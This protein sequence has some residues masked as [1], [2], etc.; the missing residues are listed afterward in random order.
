MTFATATSS[1]STSTVCESCWAGTLLSPG[2]GRGTS[3]AR[4]ES[5]SLAYRLHALLMLGLLVAYGLFVA[6]AWFSARYVVV[7]SLETRL[8]HDRDTLL[9]ALNQTPDRRWILDR[10]RVPAIYDRAFSGHYYQ[11]EIGGQKIVSRS[12]FGQLVADT[13]SRIPAGTCRQVE[14][15]NALESF[16]LACHDVIS[17]Q[18]VTLHLWIAEDYS[19]VAD[20]LKTLIWRLVLV[21]LGSLLCLWA[22]QAWALKREFAVFQALHQAL[23]RLRTDAAA[24][25]VQAYPKELQPLLSAL[26]QLLNQLGRRVERSRH[27]LGNL[28]H[29]LKRPI[30]HMRICIESLSEEASKPLDRALSQIE[31]LVQRELKRARI[32]GPVRAGQM[33]R[34]PEDIESLVDV[35]RRLYPGKDVEG[36]CTVNATVAADREDLSELMGNLLD[37]ACKY[38]DRRVVWAVTREG[39]NVCLRVEDDGPG[40][41]DE[42][43]P[44]LTAWGVRLDETR[45]GHGMGLALCRAIVDE[46]GGTLRFQTSRLGGLEV[47]VCLPLMAEQADTSV[48]QR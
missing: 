16:W 43:L 19:P 45:H 9:V 6:I 26:G 12:L 24:I 48:D 4:T 44:E 14:A 2:V 15:P 34:L 17:K 30:Q 8:K 42:A 20:G 40:V 32:V 46:Y 1:R 18:G 7:D 5:P 38:A 21:G 11:L 31:S 10:L 3:L 22:A 29:E 47:S 33:A 35:L 37:N 27:A 36:H 39:R 23:Q 28:A 41:P 25:D 13:W